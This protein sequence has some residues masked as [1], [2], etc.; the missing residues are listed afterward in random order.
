MIWVNHIPTVGSWAAW[1]W[2]HREDFGP[3]LQR[4]GDAGAFAHSALANPEGALRRVGNTLVFGQADGGPRVLAFIEQTGPQLDAIKSA[5]NG[6]HMQNA[7]LSASL[8]SLHTVSMVSL[9]LVALTPVVLTAQLLALGHRLKAI[10]TVLANIKGMIEARNE[11]ELRTG[12]THLSNGEKLLRDGKD[13]R[14][15]L[16][17]ALDKCTQSMFFFDGL[18]GRELGAKTPRREGVSLL[19]RQ[20]AVALGGTVA[21]HIAL[22][23]DNFALEKIDRVLP[24]L[25]EAVKWTFGKT[26]GHNTERFLE[27]GLSG[28]KVD[29][30][31][32]ADLFNQASDAG[33]GVAGK[34]YT[35]GSL[36][37][38][39]RPQVAN[40]GRPS[41]KLYRAHLAGL[42][43]ELREAQASI[44]ETNRIVGLKSLIE[45]TRR[46]GR[47]TLP[48][49]E[50]VR[51]RAEQE[52]ADTSPYVVWALQ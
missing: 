40:V 41:F 37:E 27:P 4:F 31:F 13:S 19:S 30:T 15:R 32:L 16:N 39:V 34:V 22:G 28:H 20:C 3:A 44:E 5:V 8:A 23:E 51:S 24:R 42:V 25:Q 33:V 38:E 10:G 9:G 17:D 29:L 36:F 7:A 43:Q 2:Q 49:M 46:A 50:E 18:L 6:L 21:A 11:A 1:L 47:E 14:D 26:V 45:E 52:N 35:E 12:L 48:V